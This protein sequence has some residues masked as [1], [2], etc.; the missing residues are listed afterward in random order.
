[1]SAAKQLVLVVDDDTITRALARETLEQGDFAVEEAED[2]EAGLAAFERLRPGIVLLDVMMPELDGFEAC[3]AL[4]GLE[5]GE[6]IP[7]LMMT[8]LDDA[9][10]INRAFEV[11]ATDFITKPIAWPMLVHRVRYLL[12]ANRAFLDL[13]QSEA[14]LANAQRIAKLGHWEW[15]LATNHVQRSD[16]IYTIVGRTRNELL[17]T[18][19]AF[20][21]VLHMDDRP[22]FDEAIEGALRR[23]QP[24]SMD[25]R[26][27]R[28]DGSIRIVHQQSELEYDG[29]GNI[30]RM[31]GTTQDITERK[32]AEE[33]IRQL[34][35]YDSLTGLP[36]RNL[37]KEQLTHALTRAG[38]SGEMLAVLL[39][40]LNRFKRVNETLG[41]Q[42]G[43]ALLRETANRLTKTLRQADYV[44]R[45]D[46][47]D[48]V[49]VAHQGADEFSVLLAGIDEVQD[50]NKVVR[51]ILEVVSQPF[52]LG[53][54]EVVLGANI[55]IA[56]HP[57]DGQD[58]EGLQ[59]NARTAMYYANQQGRDN[60]QFYNKQM[61]ASAIENLALEASLRKALEKHEFVLHY[62]PK[63]NL[64]DGSIGGLEA[65]IRWND[66]ETGI[67]PPAR[68]IPLL[69]ETGL[70]LDV[71][72]WAIHKALED[73][74]EWSAKG[75]RPPR[76]AVN[77]SS[78]QL[79]QKDFADVV[80]NALN[81]SHDGA[82]GLDLEITESL[83][84][85][86]IEGNIGKLRAIRD[87]GVD[88]AID[89]FG[90]GYSSLGYVA[91]LP[92]QCLK[93]DRSFIVTML[94]DSD[95]MA[96]VRMIVSLA[97]TLRLKV[98]AEG[99]ETEEQANALRILKCDQAQGYLY[100]KPL[101]FTEMTA[102]L[103]QGSKAA[104]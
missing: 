36:N 95:T 53:G 38:R 90:T 87:M 59:N 84:M 25:F 98:V 19:Q 24:F 32:R 71:G 9:E 11:G 54:N 33:Q 2:G 76:I 56:I 62:Q 92:V 81:G 41:Y 83:L 65:V 31:L 80:R 5:G 48:A 43:D 74:K 12:R 88:I 86:D 4:R 45:H 99:V 68:F 42:F 96:L 40:D 60:Y 82:H 55:G 1:M 28:P 13:A 30:R 93:I 78:I 100:S 17:A 47:D 77:V 79:R 14:R 10:S 97:Q 27:V 15:D 34:V 18:H 26:V 57:L 50:V 91:R 22:L 16:E 63:S 39:L 72:R 61:N 69:E 6:H 89:D 20:L 101:S 7:V 29:A 51:R 49:M 85:E 103:E 102:L 52:D 37:F 70:I 23:G 46:P 3:A 21:D 8:G 67:V 75:L 58:A 104:A 94:N 35:L 73:Y 44:A 66:P 64:A